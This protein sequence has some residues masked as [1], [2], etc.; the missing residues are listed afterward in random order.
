MYKRIDVARRYYG[1][2]AK[3]MDETRE[4]WRIVEESHVNGNGGGHVT[5]S[6]LRGLSLSSLQAERMT[7]SDNDVTSRRSSAVAFSED[8][9][10]ED[11]GVKVKVNG[12]NGGVANGWGRG[13]EGGA[14]LLTDT[15]LEGLISAL[16]C[17]DC[18]VPGQNGPVNTCSYNNLASLYEVIRVA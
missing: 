8:V 4:K 12:T 15:L 16:R 5:P 6:R 18:Y 7:S 9:D 11:F 13:G 1:K 17:H 3:V 2:G 10:E 14:T